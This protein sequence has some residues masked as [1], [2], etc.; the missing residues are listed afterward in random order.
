MKITKNELKQIIKEE[1]SEKIRTVANPESETDSMSDYELADLSTDEQM[2][3]LLKDILSQLK[4]LN[5]QMTPAK[6]LGGSSVEKDKAAVAVAE[7]E[8]K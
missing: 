1:L 8:E 7:S 2:V 6:T 5:F 4:V 3:V